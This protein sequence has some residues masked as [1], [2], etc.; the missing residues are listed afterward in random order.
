MSFITTHGV[1]HDV[2]GKETLTRQRLER[3]ARGNCY[4]DISQTQ[5]L[6]PDNMK[7]ISQ[8][9]VEKC[10]FF[11]SKHGNTYAGV[12]W[13]DQCYCGDNLPPASHLR[14]QS[15]CDTQCPGDE[16]QTCGGHWKMNVFNIQRNPVKSIPGRGLVGSTPKDLRPNKMLTTISECGPEF[17][18]NVEINLE[19]NHPH[20]WGQIFRFTNNSDTDQWFVGTRIPAVW[21]GSPHRPGTNDS[22]H[23]AMA[24]NDHGN[25]FI[26]V[27]DIPTR[28]W[29][30][31][32]LAQERQ[33]EI[34]I[35]YFN[36]GKIVSGKLSLLEDHSE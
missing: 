30:K 31:L 34:P 27:H 24:I 9:T 33:V 22:I 16:S 2:V 32:T 23:V 12:Q 36:M 26:D 35:S 10:L 21:T 4:R 1:K 3:A 8:M 7:Q 28:E 25:Y 20:V 14:P 18:I 17:E 19:N 6:L 11:C 15:E 13:R 29:F 5:R